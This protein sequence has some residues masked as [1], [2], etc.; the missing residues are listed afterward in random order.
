VCDGVSDTCAADSFEPATTVCRAASAGADCDAAEFCTGAGAACPADSPLPNGTVCRA[1]S[2]GEECDAAETC[3]GVAFTCPADG[4]L[5]NG[6]ACSS[7]GNACTVDACDGTSHLCQHPAGNAGATCRASAGSCDVAETCSGASTVCP[8]DASAPNGSSCSDGAFCNGAETCQSGT[9]TAGSSPCSMSQSCNEATDQCFAGDCP[10]TPSTCRSAGKSIVLVKDN[11]DNSKDK[12][13]YKWLKGDATT[14]AD[15]ADPLNTAT[16][17]VCFYTNA[18]L[19]SQAAVPPSSTKWSPI[20]TKGYKYKDN[21]LA[22]DGIQKIIAKGSTTAGK[23]KLLVKGKG[24]NLPD[25]LSLPIAPADLPLRVQVRNNQT[26]ICFGSSFAT[27]TKNVAG[28][29]KG[30]TP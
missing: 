29:F 10:T 1:A 20:S 2:S 26:G 17:A 4:A 30:K 16:Y 15:L 5:P 23:S 24:A 18:G 6:T 14:Q 9:C 21:T 3:N 25:T 19:V 11:A 27:P 22:E 8:A 12:L 7:D 13:V 28:Q